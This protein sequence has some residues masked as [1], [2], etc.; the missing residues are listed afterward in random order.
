MSKARKTTKVNKGKQQAKKVK[1]DSLCAGKTHVGDITIFD[2]AGT[3]VDLS[4]IWEEEYENI[5]ATKYRKGTRNYSKVKGEPSVNQGE[6]DDGSPIFIIARQ[7]GGPSYKSIDLVCDGET[8]DQE[9]VAYCAISKGFGMQDV[10]SFTLGP[11]VGEGLCVVNAAFSKAICPFHIEGG[12]T[13]DLKRKGYW[14]RSRKPL[15]KVEIIDESGEFNLIKVD[16]E[17]FSAEEWLRDNEDLWFEEW[18]K[19]RKYVALCSVGSFKWDRDEVP[20]AFKAGDEYL[21]FVE[22]KKRCYIQPAYELFRDNGVIDYLESLRERGW[23]IAL[24]HPKARSGK[25]TQMTKEQIRLLYDDKC[26]MACMPYVVC[27]YL[28]DVPI[29]DQ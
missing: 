3:K 16:G 7:R 24:V 17:Y 5:M 26:S 25:E 23:A 22:W 2:H 12:G 20:I 8:I 29:W 27:G 28:L 21:G 19:W 18:D 1:D 11:V 14:K 6:R 9:N 4:A 15:R 10:S 13:V